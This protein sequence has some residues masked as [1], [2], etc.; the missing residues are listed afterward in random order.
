MN[1]EIDLHKIGDPLKD[2]IESI[3]LFEY[4]NLL[5]KYQLLRLDPY[6][7]PF[8][9]T[10]GC[11]SREKIN[12]LIDLL[13][14]KNKTLKSLNL[15]RCVINVETIQKLGAFKDLKSLNLHNTI[16]LSQNG[17]NINAAINQENSI[18]INIMNLN[19][20]L[21]DISNNIFLNKPIII[22]AMKSLEILSMENCVFRN[23]L[24]YIEYSKLYNLRELDISGN[25]VFIEEIEEISKLKNLEL[26]YCDNINIRNLNQNINKFNI[27]VNN[28][29][30][31]KTLEYL[32]VSIMDMNIIS[33][34]DQIVYS[35]Q[36]VIIDINHNWMIDDEFLLDKI[37]LLINKLPKLKR[38]RCIFNSNFNSREIL[39]KNVKVIIN[40]EIYGLILLKQY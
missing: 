34:D 10:K 22:S 27:L 1:K 35:G 3:P 39:I 23:S 13:I 31:I 25:Q 4:S 38:L 21:L 36:D 7:A 24:E 28:I 30:K 32:D 8:H 9:I 19:L 29:I 33:E 6:F 15:S 17:F 18:L 26:L 12:K 40:E 37:N 5:T 14:K 2:Y 16:N 20:K 11:L